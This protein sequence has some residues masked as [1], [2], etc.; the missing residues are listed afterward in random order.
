MTLLKKCCNTGDLTITSSGTNSNSYSQPDKV[1]VYLG[2]LVGDDTYYGSVCTL[3]HTYSVADISAPTTNVTEC[4]V[5]GLIGK[6]ANS[7]IHN[8]YYAGQLQGKT[9]MGIAN[10]TLN[11]P[12]DIYYLSTCGASSGHGEAKTKEESECP[13]TAI[14]SD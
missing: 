11:A 10:G 4:Y 5:A 13:T 9:I 14:F 8:S 7:A 2:G 1:N 3:S 6:A 12:Y